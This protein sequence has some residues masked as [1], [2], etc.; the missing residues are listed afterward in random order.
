M[1]ELYFYK[2]DDYDN[3]FKRVIGIKPSIGEAVL[4]EDKK[5]RVIDIVTVYKSDGTDSI[6]VIVE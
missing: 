2:K 3:Y 5:Y 1:V 6:D 4:I